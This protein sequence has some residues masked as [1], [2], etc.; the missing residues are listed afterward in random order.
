M[1]QK[2]KSGRQDLDG[3]KN[4]NLSLGGNAVS[5]EGMDAPPGDSEIWGQE[6]VTIGKRDLKITR[7][8]GE[9]KQNDKLGFT[10]LSHPTDLL[11]HPEKG[12]ELKRNM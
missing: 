4:E 7:Q 1:L 12:E 6:H 5:D 9:T 2:M 8:P 3:E 10:V 11:A